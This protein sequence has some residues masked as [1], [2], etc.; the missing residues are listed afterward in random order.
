MPAAAVAAEVFGQTSEELRHSRCPDF[1]MQSSLE[2]EVQ[3]V[4][5]T[6][7][8]AAAIL[9]S[10]PSFPPEEEA[11][12]ATTRLP[13]V[14]STAVLAEVALPQVPGIHRL[15]A[16]EIRQPRFRRR[17]TTVEM[18]SKVPTGCTTRLEVEAEVPQSGRMAYCRHREV[19][20]EMAFPARFQGL[21]QTMQVAAAGHT[22]TSHLFCLL[23]EVL[24]DW[25]AVAAGPET[26]LRLLPGRKIPAGAAGQDHLRKPS[27]H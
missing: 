19:P 22:Q 4:P 20:V 10:C 7:E 17:E 6:E 16:P 21:P 9:R 1:P 15:A 27:R 26:A 24:V 8:P 2:E 5:R 25:E 14:L 3:V 18:E 23:L 11:E 12:R 13:S